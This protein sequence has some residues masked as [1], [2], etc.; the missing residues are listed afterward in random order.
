MDADIK[1]CL[2]KLTK[3]YKSFEH[4]GK[5]MTR[6]EVKYVLK[7]G[8]SKGYKSVSQIP[9]EEID[10]IIF[11]ITNKNNQKYNHIESSPLFEI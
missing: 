3:S 5:S 1:V 11:E 2:D 9:D 8:L 10:K 4:K 7:Y 6:E